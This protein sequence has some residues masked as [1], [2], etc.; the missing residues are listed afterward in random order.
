MEQPYSQSTPPANESE[1][2]ESQSQNLQPKPRKSRKFLIISIIVILC[3]IIGGGLYVYFSERRSANDEQIAYE[4]LEENENPQDYEK[5]L[6]DYPNSIHSEEVRIRLE[7][8][9]TMI[10][11][12]Q[13]IQSSSY[14]DDFIKFKNTYKSMQYG[15]LCD[16]K[17]DSLDFVLAQKEG[18]EESFQ[19]YLNMHPDG[20]YASEASVAQGEIRDQEI[21]TSD[22]DQIMQVISDFYKG[23]EKQDET[24]IC[25]NITATMTQFLSLK[26][27][28]KAQVLNSVKSMFNDHIQG[29]T[30]QVNRDID[31]KRVGG[32][33][34]KQ[35]S[36]VATFTVDQHIQRDNEGK[37]FGSF[38]CTAA[39]SNQ[40]LIS[41]LQMEEL[42]RQ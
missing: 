5:Y 10:E 15:R 21:S 41:S 2:N 24:L 8:L 25:S 9:N 29:C 38:K 36:Y 26:N 12:W 30:F 20:R 22:R 17:I 4:I 14:V 6:E 16:I 18:T 33:D 34:S 42:S 40:L 32:K 11:H 13:K 3:F 23:F 1:L 28:S 19:H 27:A 31:I 37:T 7:H 39:V 35:S